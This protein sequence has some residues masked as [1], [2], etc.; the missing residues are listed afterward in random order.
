MEIWVFG[1]PDLAVDAVPI[2]I[3]PRLRA[4]FPDHQFI[5]QD[6][7]D[8]WEMPRRLMIIDTIQG[9]P[10]V[11]AFTSLDAFQNAPHVTM[12]DFDLGTQLQFMQ[13]LGKLSEEMVIFGVPA[14]YGPDG[15]FDQLVPLLR[16]YGL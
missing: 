11:Q 6:P 3:L 4:A 13:K 8:E 15:A 2:Q 14:G 7:L 1:N 16:Q 12:H 9:I 5:H 10:S